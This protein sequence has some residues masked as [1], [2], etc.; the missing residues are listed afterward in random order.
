MNFQELSLLVQSLI[1]VVIPLSIIHIDDG[2]ER[3]FGWL[4]YSSLAAALVSF[5][6]TMAQLI[7]GVS[8]VE[9]FSG[10][11]ELNT[12]GYIL[13]LAAELSTLVVLIGSQNQVRSWSARS[14]FISLVLLT[15]LGVIY[16]SFASNVLV[17]VTSWA[18]ASAATYAI[19]MIV[20][21]PKSVDGG[22]KYLIMGIVSS[23]IMIFGFAFLVSTTGTLSLLDPLP[24][25]PPFLELALIS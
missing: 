23:S 19:S 11:L 9:I 2:S 4:F 24:S 6:L 1:L 13:S 12:S 22:I 8:T 15:L 3:R 18:L 5:L 21:D 17:V 16:L 14:S 25:S 10:T 20:K 7:Y